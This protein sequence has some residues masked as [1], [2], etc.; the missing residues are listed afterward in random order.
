MPLAH[1]TTCRAAVLNCSPALIHCAPVALPLASTVICETRAPVTSFA[2][3]LI[4]VGQYAR[5][6]EALA[7][8]GQPCVQVP[9]RAHAAR[10]PIFW[11]GIALACG[12]QCHPSLFIDSAAFS[13]YLPSG[14]GG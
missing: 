13:P 6:N 12:H 10:L 7:P 8:S 9:H 14:I 2:P 11:L 5:S 1:S 4:A 3:A